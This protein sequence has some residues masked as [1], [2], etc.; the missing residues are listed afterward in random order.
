MNI[1][2]GALP[3]INN[4]GSSAK[5]S[6]RRDSNDDDEPHQMVDEYNVE[7]QA[8]TANV[9]VEPFYDGSD[10]I[11]VRHQT[12]QNDYQDQLLER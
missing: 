1:T 12:I 3:T 10:E 8:G 9:K 2:S 11:H 6:S 5:V 4:N 7:E